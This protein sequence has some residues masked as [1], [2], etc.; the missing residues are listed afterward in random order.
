MRSIERILKESRVIAVVGLSPDPERESHQVAEYLMRHGY[1]VAPV[2]PTVD[3]VLG[4]VS[5]P[6]LRS[7]P[8]QVD[9]V[10]VFRRP[11]QVMPVAEEAIAIGA[12][13]LWLQFGVV[14][15]EAAERAWTW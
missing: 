5:Y 15:Q 2:N 4:E 13:A 7:A 6:V 11:D 9:V 3:S 12:K 8:E 1:R 10:N 14:N